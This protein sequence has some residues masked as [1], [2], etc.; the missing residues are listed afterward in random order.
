MQS[1]I[2]II[3]SAERMPLISLSSCIIMR[4]CNETAGDFYQVELERENKVLMIILMSSDIKGLE[5][6]THSI[7]LT[8]ERIVSVHSNFALHAKH[9]YHYVVLYYSILD[10]TD[11]ISSEFSTE[12]RKNDAIVF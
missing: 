5:Y 12:V 11:P 4:V 1:S 10:S 6:T 3:I 2:C 7:H 9:I 8:H